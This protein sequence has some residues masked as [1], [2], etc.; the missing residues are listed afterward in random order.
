MIQILNLIVGLVSDYIPLIGS[1]FIVT[2]LAIVLQPS[3][4]KHAP[5]YYW[6]VGLLAGYGLLSGIFAM[7][8]HP[9]L[10]YFKIPILRKII[11]QFVHIYGF[12]F[13][14]LILI[15]YMGALSPQNRWVAKLMTIRKE[16]SIMVGFSV[17]AH[18]I[19][20][21]IHITPTNLRYIFKGES[22]G[23]FHGAIINPQSELLMNIAFFIGLFMVALFLLLWVT[24]FT[25]VHRALG[26]KRWKAIQR[27]SYLL[28]GLLFCH[29]VLLRSAWIIASIEQGES[30]LKYAIGLATTL[31]IFISYLVL[32][33]KKACK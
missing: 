17:L 26:G 30:C 7:L 12:S 8:G 31:I 19:T 28:Y 25:K 27:W 32:R 22:M 9:E 16:L 10:A 20:R 18:A 1:L 2:F 4:K 23:A 6:V 15:M 13:P 24:S 5:I 21:I 33:L 11:P 14:M 29:S 3:I